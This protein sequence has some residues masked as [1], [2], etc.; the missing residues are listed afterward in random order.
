MGSLLILSSVVFIS[1]GGGSSK[2]GIDQ[3]NLTLAIVFS[4]LAGFTFG[5]M[6]LAI[7]YS[8]DVGFDPEQSWYDCNL[9]MALV[10]LPFF[11]STEGYTFKGVLIGFFAIILC[12]SGVILLGKAVQYGNAGPI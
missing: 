3:S 7:K 5:A 12:N 4:V 2:D 10:Y 9:F 6:T 11:L 1:L 8:L